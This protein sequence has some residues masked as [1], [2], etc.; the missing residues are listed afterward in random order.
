MFCADFNSTLNANLNQNK[1]VLF[2]EILSQ[3][4]F[5][6]FRVCLRDRTSAANEVRW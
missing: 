4:R 2:D 1:D 6:S 3:H 5:T